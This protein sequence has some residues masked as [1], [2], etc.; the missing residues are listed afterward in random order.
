MKLIM[1]KQKIIDEFM[2][3]L[4]FEKIHKTMV[5]LD[6]RWTPI[7][8]VPEIYEIRQFF[9][10]LLNTLLDENLNAIECGGFRIWRENKTLKAAFQVN[11]WEVEMIK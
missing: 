6:W 7:N 3:F 2:D 10:E 9:R 4:N 1:E 8:A 5:A 11:S